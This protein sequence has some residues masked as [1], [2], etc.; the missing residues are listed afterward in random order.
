M[1][2]DIRLPSDPAVLPP[3]RTRSARVVGALVVAAPVALGLAVLI[4]PHD[5]SDAAATLERIAGDD[6]LRWTFAHVLEPF[7][8]LF[9]SLIL[10]LAARVGTTRGRRLIQAG[11]AMAAVG[12]AATALIVYS[13]GEA[14]RFMTLPDVQ[15]AA[16]EP[17]Y[18]HFHEGVPLAGVLALLFRPGMLV[19]GIGLFR[20]RAVPRWAAALVALTPVLMVP[21]AQASPAVAA[22]L[23]GLPLAAGLAGSRRAISAAAARAAR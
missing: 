23:V 22:V 5:T 10:L 17:L 12:A 13:H 7:S 14:Y 6:R 21:A 11:A 19:L 18:V 3:P 4:H 8:W 20:S 1:P 16:M 2:I 9:L 15:R